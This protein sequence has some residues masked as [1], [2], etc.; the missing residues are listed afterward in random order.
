MTSAD[1]AH[2]RDA[3][4]PATGFYGR[5][6]GKPLRALQNQHLQEDLPRLQIDLATLSDQALPALFA[7]PVAEV[8]LE[9]GFGGGEHL[10]AEAARHPGIGYIGAEAFVNGVAKATAGIVE[11][12]LTNVRLYGDDVVPLLDRLPAGSLARIDLLYPDPWPKRRHWK[13]RFVRP[14]NI[15]R[16][17]R[18]LMPGG[19]FRF[20]T[21]VEDYAAW[22]LRHL[23]ADAR[24]H[25]T[26]RVADDWRQPWAGWPGT[27]Y[28]AK[29][30]REGRIPGYYEFQRI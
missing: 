14:D 5:R 4:A 15:D 7:L 29:A 22:T 26:A 18:L 11:A 23:L 24:F 3:A 8:R 28:E 9:I 30:R 16:F 10:L 21:D 20:A 25:W 17:A 19:H 12:G 13:R 6:K 27:R 1:N 2:A